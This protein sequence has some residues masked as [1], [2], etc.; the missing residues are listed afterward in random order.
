ME[1]YDYY[2]L[3]SK[4]T[5]AE[6]LG[7]R[8]RKELLDFINEAFEKH[9]NEFEYK[10]PTHNSWKE[11][12]KDEDDEFDAMND[13]PTYLSIWPEDDGGHEVHIYRIRQSVYES[14][15]RFFEVDGWDWNNSEFVEAWEPNSDIDTLQSIATFINAVLEQEQEI[16][17]EDDAEDE[18]TATPLSDIDR[19]I[20]YVR[21]KV[22]MD[23]VALVRTQMMERREP[24]FRVNHELSDAIYDLMEEYGADNGLP[25]GWWL[26]EHDEETVFY[27]L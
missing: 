22:N 20:I 19:A 5:N 27:E 17:G 11:K 14:G 7:E 18:P 15:Y 9:G 6:E 3:T 2:H 25:E 16:L 10:C 13:L 8:Y 24:L 12:N 21:Q 4:F 1:K 26:D 23:E